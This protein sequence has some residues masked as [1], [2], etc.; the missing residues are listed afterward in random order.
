MKAV[1]ILYVWRLS[2]FFRVRGG[3]YAGIVDAG[4][5]VFAVP[6]LHGATAFYPGF[7]FFAATHADSSFVQFFFRNGISA[8]LKRAA[9]SK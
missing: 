8:R 7:Y 4:V 9:C 3:A 5:H 1:S 6:H 2:F